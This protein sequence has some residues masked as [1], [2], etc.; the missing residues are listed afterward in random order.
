M[1]MMQLPLI[2][3]G[4]F[5]VEGGLLTALIIG[6]LFGFALERSG[7]GNAKKLAAQFYFYDMTVFKVMFTSILVAMTG[8]YALGTLG[9]IDLNLV[10]LNPTFFWPQLLGGFLLGVGFIISGLCPGTSFVALASGKTDALFTIAGVFVGILLFAF[11]LDSLPILNSLYTAPS[12]GTL[13]LPDLLGVPAIWFAL[14]VVL[15]ATAAFVGAEK[16]E[17]IFQKKYADYE[18]IERSLVPDKRGKFILAG[19]L[20]VICLIAG[21]FGSPSGTTSADLAS[22]PPTVE[23]LK[24]LDLADEIISLNPNLLIMDLRKDLAE[25]ALRIPGA[26]PAADPVAAQ[27]WVNAATEDAM[28]VL[29]LA[30]DAEAVV[31]NGWPSNRRYF[32]LDRGIASWKEEVILPAKL[33]SYDSAQQEFVRRQNQISAYFSGAK[34]ESSASAPPPPAPS[35]GKKKKKAAGGC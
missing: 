33:L 10:W 24:A 9:W 23:T 7:F 16:V 12:A 25:D 27:P 17:G 11:G 13:T 29:L 6:I 30:G 3:Q 28:V 35:G 18:G 31:P 21:L 20:S 15:M 34:V 1:D 32:A 4:A 2:P 26:L 19:V 8:L 14:G 22:T 5:G